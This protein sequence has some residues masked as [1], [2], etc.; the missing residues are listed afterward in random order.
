MA[1]WCSWRDKFT[2]ALAECLLIQAA[3]HLDV[4]RSGPYHA[5]LGFRMFRWRKY[6]IFF[7]LT[8]LDFRVQSFILL[9][10]T[11]RG[12][13]APPVGKGEIGLKS[14][15]ISEH[16]AFFLRNCTSDENNTYSIQSHTKPSVKINCNQHP[17]TRL[18]SVYNKIGTGFLTPRR[19]EIVEE[20]CEYCRERALCCFKISRMASGSV[21]RKNNAFRNGSWECS[22]QELRVSN[23]PATP[24]R[25]VYMC[26]INTIGLVI[27]LIGRLR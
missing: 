16:R 10:V 15:G 23:P 20:D 19:N 18:F 9:R 11:E 5:P 3:E 21:F 4:A 8:R 2:N 13:N 22:V 1:G 6:R 14:S 12:F 26:K 17:R 25:A 27:R 24:T 7:P